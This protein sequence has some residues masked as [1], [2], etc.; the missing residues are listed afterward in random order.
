[1]TVFAPFAYPVS[2]HRR[3]HAPTA[4]VDYQNYKPWLRDEF[5]FRCVYCLERERWYP[6][7]AAAFSVDH[8]IPRVVDPARIG[9]YENMV[10][11]CLRCNSN[12]TDVQLADPTRV[13]LGECLAIDDEGTISALNPDG[14]DLIAVLHLNDSPIL[15][16]RKK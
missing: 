4:Y 5:T 14:A 7:R 15:D 12:K 13:G 2:A 8:V 3:R 9:N 16:T 1:M 11:A 6:S 10:Y